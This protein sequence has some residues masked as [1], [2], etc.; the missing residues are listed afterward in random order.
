M[1]TDRDFGWGAVTPPSGSREGYV[2]RRWVD[3]VVPTAL[4]W[5][6]PDE[7]WMTSYTAES[8]VRF[9]MS[10]DAAVDLDQEDT[11]AAFVPSGIAN[12]PL[13]V[14]RA[15]DG[16]VWVSTFSQVLRLTPIAP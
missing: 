6:T 2:I 1:Q 13:C 12:K 9:R 3:V 11:F 4:A 7:L 14:R 5:V 10:G 15:P 8:I 16:A